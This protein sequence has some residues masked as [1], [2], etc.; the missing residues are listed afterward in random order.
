MSK[1]RPS[2][3]PLCD[4]P[5]SKAPLKTTRP[6]ILDLDLKPKK[7][8]CVQHFR[9]GIFN[10][11]YEIAAAAEAAKDN[12]VSSKDKDDIEMLVKHQL[13]SGEDKDPFYMKLEVHQEKIMDWIVNRDFESIFKL[14]TAVATGMKTGN[15]EDIMRI[16]TDLYNH[17]RDAYQGDSLVSLLKTLDTYEEEWPNMKKVYAKDLGIIQSSG[18]GKSRLAHELGNHHF[19]IPF[20]FRRRGDNGYPSGDTEVMDFLCNS[21]DFP[22][23]SGRVLGFFAAVSSMGKSLPVRARIRVSTRENGTP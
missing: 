9:N 23:S 3:T 5:K 16:K 21:K 4:T 8:P 19:T 2:P 13:A 22:S 17:W 14:L 10:I 7:W 20:I 1:R 18:M 12:D 11:I 15:S 6:W